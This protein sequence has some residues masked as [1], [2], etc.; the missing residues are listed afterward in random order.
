MIVENFARAILLHRFAELWDAYPWDSTAVD[1]FVANYPHAFGRRYGRQIPALQLEVLRE[2]LDT[3]RT[4]QLTFLDHF[5]DCVSATH[6][7]GLQ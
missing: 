4:H 1:V 6:P 2:E 3:D 5:A 7:Q